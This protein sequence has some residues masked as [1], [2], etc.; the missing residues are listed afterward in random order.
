M[1][2]TIDYFYRLDQEAAAKVIAD[3]CS[4]GE[5]AASTAYMYMQGKR[6]PMALYQK[7]IVKLIKKHYHQS[8]SRKELFS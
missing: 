8:V 6:K 5:V 7:L 3:L 4:E 2:R 1:K